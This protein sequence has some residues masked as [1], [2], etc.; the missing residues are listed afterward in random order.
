MISGN[1]ILLWSVYLLSNIQARMTWLGYRGLILPDVIM[2]VSFMLQLLSC[3]TNTAIYAV[4]QTKFRE[5]LKEMLK[6]PFVSVVRF[7]K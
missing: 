3:C 5:Q 7:I 1:F 4:T 6:Y 2:E